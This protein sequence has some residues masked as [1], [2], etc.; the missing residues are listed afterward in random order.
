MCTCIHVLVSLG[1]ADS[2]VHQ[3]LH[4]VMLIPVLLTQ[5]NLF[6]V[7]GRRLR[8]KL[9]IQVCVCVWGGGGGGGEGKGGGRVYVH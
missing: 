4:D 3:W 7:S 9:H 1:G 2:A 8:T 6:T 5:H